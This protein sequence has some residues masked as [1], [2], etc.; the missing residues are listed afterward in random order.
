M[1]FVS[2]MRNVCEAIAFLML[3]R[4]NKNQAVLVRLI[5]RCHIFLVRKKL[6][7]A[8]TPTPSPNPDRNPNLKTNITIKYS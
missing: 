5:V 2:L 8:P 6:K 7:T 4:V 1:I 3:F